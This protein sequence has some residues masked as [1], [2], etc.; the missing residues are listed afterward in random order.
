[1]KDSA[2][3]TSNSTSYTAKQI[4]KGVLNGSAS[5]LAKPEYPA[6]A[7][8]VNAS[9]AVN[10][11]V[12]I[13]EQG[14]VI[15]ASAVSGHPLLQTAATEAARNSKFAPTLLQGNAVKVTGIIVYNFVAP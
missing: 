7:R 3:D 5:T 6:A 8:A 15:S 13:D 1:M 4:S 12:M 11:Q 14:N 2:G 10:V 9:G